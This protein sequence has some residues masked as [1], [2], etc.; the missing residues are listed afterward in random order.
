[1]SSN[2]NSGQRYQDVRTTKTTRRPQDTTALELSAF[3]YPDRSQPEIAGEVPAQYWENSPPPGL[4][5]GGPP[6][7]AGFSLEELEGFISAQGLGGKALKDIEEFRQFEELRL[8]RAVQ[9][10]EQGGSSSYFPSGNPFDPEDGA[11]YRRMRAPID[12]YDRLM[13]RQY[14]KGEDGRLQLKALKDGLREQERQLR[15]NQY[16][17]APWYEQIPVAVQD[18]ARI[19]TNGATL[20]TARYA[21]AALEALR[22]GASFADS[23]KAY[24][25]KLEASRDRASSAGTALEAIGSVGAG[26]LAKRFGFTFGGGRVSENMPGMKGELTRGGLSVLD[27]A[28]QS[29]VDAFARG[30]SVPDK[31]VESVVPSLISIGTD[32]IL[33]KSGPSNFKSEA[34]NSR[35]SGNGERYTGRDFAVDISGSLPQIARDIVRD[36]QGAPELSGD[37]FVPSYRTESGGQL[38]QPAP[39]FVSEPGELIWNP[40]VRR[41]LHSGR[42]RDYVGQ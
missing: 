28:A 21:V 2:R 19:L 42:I 27:G 25:E 5:D 8:Q 20:S 41:L 40:D 18:A 24:E 30:E 3:R 36:F 12:Y 37:D 14:V 22:T 29:G 11:E 16:H 1:M 23:K 26:A 9:A 33:P 13:A 39:P 15:L 6:P 32:K 17:A 34:G 4:F 35:G 31:M 38:R 10:R 7:P